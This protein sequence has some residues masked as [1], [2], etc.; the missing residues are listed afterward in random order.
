MSAL[1]KT[2]FRGLMRRCPDCGAGKIFDGY[3]TPKSE[4]P[5]C[6]SN[7]SGVRTD[8]AAPWATILLVG[9]MMAP[10]VIMTIGMDIGTMALTALFMIVSMVFAAAA[11]PIMKGLFFALNWHLG[12]RYDDPDEW[13]GDGVPGSIKTS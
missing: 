5:I 10:V 9:H 3:L 13:S 4:C 7:F 6:Q 1:K 11:L 2:I 12:V 8:D